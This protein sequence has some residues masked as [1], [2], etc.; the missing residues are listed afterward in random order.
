MEIPPSTR[1]FR[2]PS[3]SWYSSCVPVVKR[4]WS[5][6]IIS[7]GSCALSRMLSLSS[8]PERWRDFDAYQRWDSTHSVSASTSMGCASSAI[9]LKIPLFDELEP[10]EAAWREREQIR[11]L[12]DPWEARPAE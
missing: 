11:Q 3:G 10:V 5:S 2:S 6:A 4:A 7:F 1:S 8:T 9:A 12:P